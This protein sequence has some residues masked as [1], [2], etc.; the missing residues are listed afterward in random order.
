MS[1]NNSTSSS[2]GSGGGAVSIVERHP[3][4]AVAAVVVGG[5][6]RRSSSPHR[7]LR[8][9]GDGLL[10]PQDRAWQMLHATSYEAIQLNK[11]I[12][13]A[14]KGVAVKG[15]GRYCSHRHRMPSSQ[16]T[17]VQTACR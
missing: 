5:P 2:S 9:A 3:A 10:R 14:L 6:F 4:C 11:Q 12:S 8:L 16:E 17:K 13:N 15:P 7:R 1:I